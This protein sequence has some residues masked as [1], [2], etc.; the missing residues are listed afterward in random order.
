MFK[1]FLL[2]C[3]SVVLM[4]SMDI[5]P[6][7]KTQ[8]YRANGKNYEIF[9]ETNGS[10]LA[11]FYRLISRPAPPF[12]IEPFEAAELVSTYGELEVLEFLV[13][14]QG[15]VVDVRSLPLLEKQKIPGAQ[16]IPFRELLSDNQIRAQ[17]LKRLGAV[18]G[19]KGK[20]YFK[21]AKRIVIYSNAPWCSEASTIIEVLLTLGYPPQ[22][23]HYYRGGMQAWHLS[24]LIVEEVE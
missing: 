2:L 7:Q 1:A 24:A 18:K 8:Q 20:W 15:V 10:H 9:R 3:C 13:R 23:L 11:E 19:K 22:K 6:T 21:R 17:H 16:H 12:F 5:T 4:A 14:E